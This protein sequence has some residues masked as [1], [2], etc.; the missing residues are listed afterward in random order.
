[1]KKSLIALSL[2]SAFASTLS[3]A[4]SSTEVKSLEKKEAEVDEVIIVTATRS[5]M[6]SSEILSSFTVISRE[7]IDQLPVSSLAELLNTIT[8]FQMSQNGGAGQTTS[9]FTRGTN[10]GHTLVLIDGQ[11]ISSATL[12]QVDFANLSLAQIERVEVIKG[13]KASIWGSDAIGGVIQIFTRQLDTGEISVDLGYGNQNQK[14]ASLSTAFAHGHGGT[15][16]TLT[17]KASDGYDVFEPEEPD[18]DGY[19]QENISLIGY[20][21]INKQWKVNW[22]AKYDQGNSEYDNSFGA[23]QSAFDSQQWQVSAQQKTSNWYQE[24]RLGSQ[25]NESITFGKSISEKEGSFFETDRLQASWLGSYQISPVLSSNIGIDLTKEKV[26]TLSAYNQNERNLYAAFTHLNFDNDSQFIGGSIRYDNIEDV[27]NEVTYSVSVGQRF[28]ADTVVSFNIGSGFKAP[29]FNDLYYPTDA[30]SYGN[31]DLSPETSTSIEVLFKTSFANIETELSIYQTEIDNLIEWDV[32]ENYKYTPTNIA[33]AEI[34]GLEL[35]F[36]G[37]FFNANHELQL[38]Y[39]DAVNTTT[40]LPL[41]RRSKN[42]A[43]YQL[44]RQWQRL[45]VLASINYQ[46]E[47]EDTQWPGTI[48]LESYTL[49]DVSASYH[50]NSA[51]TAGIKINNL[52]DKDYTS[53]TNYIGQP[54]QY[55]LTISYRQ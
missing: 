32:D 41:I 4:N 13:P 50:I 46:G 21:N 5:P 9:V 17:A 51:W 36:S 12:G 24:F 39:L 25:K 30:Y 53:A 26:D 10:A 19:N 8:G 33:E 14:Q 43:R 28:S 2:T 35:N 49:V 15:T 6:N 38:G 34:K 55:L 16:I 48:T 29:S 45:S 44:S 37:E 47:R 27:D 11:R 3:Y 7:D 54:A 22:L 20:Q 18:S 31:A 23:D 52:L 1:M 40:N 42:S